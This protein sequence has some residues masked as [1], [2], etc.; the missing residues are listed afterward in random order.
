MDFQVGQLVQCKQAVHPGHVKLV[1]CVGEIKERI[2]GFAAF[3]Y[4][5]EYI[6]FFPNYPEGFCPYCDK[7][8][9]PL[10]FLMLHRELKPIEDPDQGAVDTETHELP[11]E[12]HA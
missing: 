7:H 12:L 4:N 2:N 3:I 9:N 8:H 1:G 6:V 10:Y 5:C 11:E